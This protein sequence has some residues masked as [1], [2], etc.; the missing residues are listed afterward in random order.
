MLYDHKPPLIQQSEDYHH[1]IFKHVTKEGKNKSQAK[2]LQAKYHLSKSKNYSPIINYPFSVVDDDD[3][4]NLQ[5]HIAQQKC[6]LKPAV[7]WQ[8]N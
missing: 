8:R 3:T 1:K 6:R 5:S 7:E 4:N 2:M